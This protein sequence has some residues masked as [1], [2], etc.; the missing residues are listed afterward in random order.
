V[1][2]SG[3]ILAQ[4]LLGATMRHEHA[5]LAIPDFP[6]AYGRVWPAMDPAAVSAYNQQ[7]IEVEAARPITAFGI[8]L[9][10][11]HRL[12]AAGILGIVAFHGWQVRRRL[13]AS[14]VLG[15]LGRAWLWLVVAQLGLG[16]ATVWSGKSADVATAHMAVGAL[17]LAVGVVQCL[18]AYRVLAPARGVAGTRVQ[19]LGPAPTSP[20][21]LA[22]VPALGA[23][24]ARVGSL[25]RGLGGGPGTLE[26]A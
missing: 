11:A 1:V 23:D 15:K 24:H 14:H 13:G 2:G 19:V 25:G 18:V 26:D 3:L 4:L 21:A 16:A 7:R 8:G 20:D 12:T 6:L 17:L 10:M 9:H 5:G 22:M